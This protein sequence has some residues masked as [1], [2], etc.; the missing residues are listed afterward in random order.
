MFQRLRA[1]RT[2]W[3]LALLLVAA[4]PAAVPAAADD[5]AD[6]T[7]AITKLWG[8]RQGAGGGWPVTAC[9]N[10][11]GIAA[12][13]QA[14][15]T[16]TGSNLVVPQVRVTKSVLTTN[17]ATIAKAFLAVNVADNVATHFLPK[18]VVQG[19]NLQLNLQFWGNN[20]RSAHANENRYL[21]A[22]NLARLTTPPVNCPAGIT[23]DRGRRRVLGL[24]H[25]AQ[26]LTNE[27]KWHCYSHLFPATDR[28][29]AVP[30]GLV[31]IT[32]AEPAGN[33]S[34]Y[35]YAGQAGRF[36]FDYTQRRVYYTPTHYHLWKKNNFTAVTDQ[37]IRDNT[38]AAGSTC[39]PFF[40]FVP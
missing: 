21:P 16:N 37:E 14:S 4:G 23:S 8:A 20:M 6:M 25:A 27:Q 30:T 7:D 32:H 5:W 15:V 36:V 24:L 19:S 13:A 26:G 29:D 28:Q 31:E 40:E 1:A 22:A 39:N 33:A 35:A 3:G 9:D 18:N 38:V 2:V 34:Q 12:L 11:N 17:V 10:Y